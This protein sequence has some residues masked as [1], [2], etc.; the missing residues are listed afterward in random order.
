MLSSN[1]HLKVCSRVYKI[2]ERF[3][4]QAF[5]KIRTLLRQ[6]WLLLVFLLILVGIP[7]FISLSAHWSS[8]E[9]RWLRRSE[10]FMTAVKQGNF[11]E[12]LLA[13]HPGVMT[14]WIAGMRTFFTESSV[15]VGNLAA[16]RWFIGISVWIGL[17]VACVLLH[18]LFGFWTS[19]TCFAFLAYSPFFLAQTRR[20]HTDA[21]ATIFTLLTVLLFL[22]YCE[23]RQKR[24]YLIL[25]GVVFGLSLLAKSYSLILLGWVS[26]CLFLYQP[27]Q[28]ENLRVNLLT[29]AAVM[30]SFLGCALLTC[31]GLWPIFWNTTFG[32]LGASLL[33]VTFVLLRVWLEPPRGPEL[34]K[35]SDDSQ[36]SPHLR[37]T[38]LLSGALVLA[39]VSASVARVVWRVFDRV[40]WAV[41]TPHEVEYFFLGEIV[42]DPGWLF[43]PFV[44]FIKSTPLMLPLA[45]FSV[46]ILWKHRKDSDQTNQRFRLALALVT[47]VIIFTVGLSVVSK[48]FA[49]YL[50]PTFPI[51]EIL[52]AIGCVEFLRWAYTFFKTHFGIQGTSVKITFSIIVV[53][54][55]FLIQ[56]FPVLRL[57]PYYGTYYNTLWKV[58][59]IAKIIS[60]GDASGL[61][62][63]ASYLNA[64]PNARRLMVQVSPLAAQIVRCYFKGLAYSAE[65]GHSHGLTADYEV[66]YIRDVQIARVPQKGILNGYLEHTISLNGRDH[67]WIYRVR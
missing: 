29:N 60:V 55:F 53:L 20:V 12:T 37:Y 16:A 27:L 50:L 39:L 38:L 64:K 45:L 26:L 40:G 31:M 6:K 35:A 18:R 49:R 7:R 34:A 25:S 22:L 41:T 10:N 42:N 21:L 15:D 57:Y 44:L 2:P 14:M 54:C 24:L 19:V 61:D 48:K 63:A 51:L 46:L 43:Y 13:Y 4:R 58:T 52:A 17:V 3:P 1:T 59:D 32:L 36:S 28:N 67:V 47:V 33:S 30:L 23:N 11:T 9:A 8:D 65:S 62:L 66:V 56:V 5:E